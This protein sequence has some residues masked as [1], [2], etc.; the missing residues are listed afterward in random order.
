MTFIYDAVVTHLHESF[1]TETLFL[2]YL[3]LTSC[4]KSLDVTFGP[5]SS[6]YLTFTKKVL[7]YFSTL[8]FNE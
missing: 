6:A 7:Y 3:L 2:F 8:A 5:I 1:R 4:K